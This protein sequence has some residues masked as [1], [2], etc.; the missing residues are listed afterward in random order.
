MP[1]LSTGVQFIK[2]IGPQRAKALEKLGIS[3]LQ[4]L[5]AWF[6]RRYEDRRQAKRLADLAPDETACVRAMV[7]ASPTV[8]RIRKGMELVKV[9][10]VDGPAVLEVTFF[11]QTWLKNNLCPGQT[12]VFY[13]KAEGAGLHRKMTS[14]AVEPEGRGE[15]TGRIVPFYPLAAGVSQ[16][17]LRRS[18]RQGL[19][20]CAE[21]LPESL[22]EQ[23]RQE[24]HLCRIGYAYENIHFPEDEKALELSRRRLAFEELFFFTLVLQSLRRQREIIHVP[25]CEAVDMTPFYRALPFSLTAAQRRCVEEAVGD[26]RSGTPMNR[27]CQGDVGSGKTMVAA[28]ASC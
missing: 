11:N 27:L 3:T 25:P 16:L 24:H 21:I 7:A 19:D 5:I 13:G 26:M 6:P 17:V 12:Y 2:G 15:V 1:D 28:G 23:I 9:R 8:S 20:A 22:P 18:I 14:P 4:D 10:A